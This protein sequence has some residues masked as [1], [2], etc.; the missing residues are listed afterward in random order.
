M[1]GR[2]EISMGG[3]NGVFARFDLGSPLKLTN[4]V[5]MTRQ[6]AQVTTYDKI[7]RPFPS[8]VWML[9]I[10]LSS[11]LAIVIFTIHKVHMSED[12]IN[13]GVVREEKLTMNLFLFPITKIVEPDALPWFEK[14]STGKFVYF[15][16]MI[17]CMF[18]VLFYTSNLRAYLV[19]VDY[20]TSPEMIKDIYERGQKVYIYKQAPTQE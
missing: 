11:C 4:A 18:I 17:F 19:Y 14:W 3:I 9:N 20:E 1:T 10:L 12:L 6:P 5:Y 13:H 2:A 15:L 7:L 8:N 16:W